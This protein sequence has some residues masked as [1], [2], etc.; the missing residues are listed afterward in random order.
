[1][2]S[3]SQYAAKAPVVNY[4]S[5]VPIAHNIWSASSWRGLPKKINTRNTCGLLQIQS[6]PVFWHVICSCG[7]V[8]LI[9]G[10]AVNQK[11]SRFGAT[12]GGKK[13]Q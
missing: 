12:R 7:F 5:F 8:R 2:T 11:E 13:F 4:C 10:V 1:M 6:G 9:Q 3:E